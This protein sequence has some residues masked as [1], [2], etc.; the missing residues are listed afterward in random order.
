[1]QTLPC[2]WGAPETLK[3]PVQALLLYR[4]YFLWTV[5]ILLL[6][7]GN[8]FFL[9]SLSGFIQN[10][11]QCSLPLCPKVT[12]LRKWRG[13]ND[14]GYSKFIIHLVTGSELATALGKESWRDN[15]LE[16]GLLKHKKAD[17]V[18]VPTISTTV[19]NITEEKWSRKRSVGVVG[20][21][22]QQN[23]FSKF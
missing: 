3:P 11:S 14:D 12:G 23:K 9:L 18:W 20:T 21:N 19:K 15:I 1:M 7:N 4:W 10:C 8:N 13:F 17:P 16:N 6:E 2:I 5:W 22:F